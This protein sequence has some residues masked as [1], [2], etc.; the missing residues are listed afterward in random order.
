[1]SNEQKTFLILDGNALLHRAWH[2][3]PPLS[4]KDGVVVNAAYGFTNVIEKM[5]SAYNPD[6][7][8]VVW[9]L[10]GGT[11]RN[12]AFEAYKAQREKKPDE[13][14]AQIPII[15][16]LLTAYG[17]PSLSVKGFEGDD[18]LGTISRMNDKKGG[19]DTLIVTGDLDT[20]Q[21]VNDTTKVVFFVKGLSEVKTYDRETVF[22]RYNLRPDQLIDYK[23]LIGDTSDNLPGVAGIGEKGAKELLATY[24]TVDGIMKAL[25][26][27][28]LPEKFVKKFKGQEKTVE[29]M[30]KMVTIV[31][32]VPLKDFDYQ[33]TARKPVDV[34]ALLPK[35]R[36]LEFKTLIKKYEKKSGVESGFAAVGAD[37]RV[38]PA[39]SKKIKKAAKIGNLILTTS[40]KD[41]DTSRI[42]VMLDEKTQDLFGGSIALILLT[43]GKHVYKMSAAGKV[44]LEII[45]E[46]LKK[47]DTI[48]SHDVKA[49]IHAFERADVP[50][51]EAIRSKTFVDT[52]VAAYLLSQGGRDFSLFEVLNETLETS[53]TESSSYEEMFPHLLPLAEKLLVKLV[54]EKMLSLFSDMEMPLMPVLCTMEL[55]GIKVDQDKLRDLS[56]DFAKTIDRL[57]KEIHKLAGKEFNV[58]S[59]SQLADILFV[60]LEL[61]TKG[62]KKT[63]T[64]FSTAAP[65]LEKLAEEHEIIPLIEEYRE[66][67][68]LKSTYSDSLPTLVKKDGRIHSNFNQTIAATGRLSSKDPNLQNI[69]I[70]TE[71][72]REIRK[73]FV[74]ERGYILLSADYS[75]IELRLAAVISKDASFL[76]AF[77][78]G[79]DIHKR[80]AAEIYEVKE[81]EVTKA[82][83]EAAKAINFSILYGV[84]AR[85]LARRTK[86]SVD[87]A[88]QFIEKYFEVHPGIRDYIDAM[89]LKA[90]TDGYVETLFGRRRYLPEINSGM[91]QLIA[92][93]E[94]MAM[95]MPIQGSN[96]DIIKLAMIQIDQ[97]IRDSGLRVHMILQVHDELVFEVHEDDVKKAEKEIPK[98][99]EHIVSYEIPLVVDTGTGKRWGEIE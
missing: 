81:E 6:F 44:E 67:A 27:G 3:I 16:D 90:R 11:F 47:C 52:M 70:R 57:T 45:M 98:L 49:F 85:A 75:Q 33:M 35:L 60:D 78:D 82:Q 87:E 84:G 34:E 93:A 94:R 68:K 30:R 95:N 29:L 63:K 65:E 5:L 83:R 91:P 80:T 66:V 54:S 32:D 20:L 86:M 10:P 51:N 88:K 24:E 69:P 23:T 43:D 17:I 89:K 2:A 40:L 28:T 1:M 21:L 53:F 99:M 71:L 96:A 50:M 38:G 13:L 46:F 15:Q 73:A 31:C 55:K 64:G 8:A 12:E 48:V 25:K 41:L 4:T 7:I 58:N 26:D 77:K 72:G 61:P 97:W 19:I 37:P 9:D 62:I 18:L 42:A 56:E 76:K 59:P 79:A 39:T 22:A 74:A 14:Y 36:D 92:S